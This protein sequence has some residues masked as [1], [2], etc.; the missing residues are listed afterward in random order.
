MAFYNKNMI[1][2][3]R[4]SKI[5]LYRLISV[6][7]VFI[8]FFNSI[9]YA[10][11]DEQL[12]AIKQTA[13]S[14]IQTQIEIPKNGTI[15]VEAARIDNR[16]YATDCPK[17]LSASLPGRLN[18]SGNTSVLVE[19]QLDDWKVYVPI[20]TE[21][22]MPLVTAISPLSKGHSISSSDLALTLVNS[23][24]YRRGGY[25]NPNDIIGSRIKRSVRAGDVVEKND[26]CMV[27]RNDSVIIKAVKGELSILTKGTALGDGAL[28][29]KV[30]VENDKSKRIVS[31]IVT[32]VGEISIR[33]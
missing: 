31:G 14:F 22:M 13:E 12:N 33:F 6:I 5:T 4:D 11:T 23:R 26:I 10:A 19:C 1:I 18:T 7:G 3:K 2:K 21:L 17:P 28:G 8:S 16:I 25:A 15:N 24:T 30:N 27:C 29:D 9:A 32:A 20:K